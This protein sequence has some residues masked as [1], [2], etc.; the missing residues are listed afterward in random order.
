MG[1]SAQSQAPGTSGSPGSSGTNSA[2]LAVPSGQTI[3]IRD[4]LFE[5]YARSTDFIQQY[6]F[7]GGMLPS[8]TVFREQARLAGLVVE[9]PAPLGTRQHAGEELVG[10]RLRRALDPLGDVQA[11]LKSQKVAIQYMPERLEI[12]DAM[13]TIFWALI[14]FL[15]FS[16]SGRLSRQERC[17]SRPFVQ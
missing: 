9:A 12:I 15:V 14:A 2:V 13:P 11:Y 4:D 3:T 8:P 10:Q 1:S 5:R 6:I 16:R 7:P 17:R